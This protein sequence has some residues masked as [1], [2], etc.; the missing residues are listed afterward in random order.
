MTRR[1]HRAIGVS[2]LLAVVAAL[3]IGAG[4]VGAAPAGKA[5]SGTVYFAVTHSVAASSTRPERGLTS[6]SAR[7]RSRM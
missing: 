6:S 2:G 7:M 4:T 3:A 5:D 1:T